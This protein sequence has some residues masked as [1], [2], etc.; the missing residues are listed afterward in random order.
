MRRHGFFVGLDF[1]ARFAAAIVLALPVTAALAGTGVGQFP[2]GDRLLFEPGGL[3]LLEAARELRPFAWSLGTASLFGFGLLF[4]VL[5]VPHG[6]LLASLSANGSQSRSAIFARALERLP[7]LFALSSLGLLAQIAVL[8]FAAS[9]GASVRAAL[10]DRPGATPELVGLAILGVGLVAAVL[11]GMARDLSRAA[12]VTFGIAGPAALRIGLGALGRGARAALP[13]W[14]GPALVSAL[15]V[16]AA[17]LVTGALDVSRPG[18]LRVVTV[19]VVHGVVGYAL[20]WCRAFWLSSS[21][22]LLNQRSASRR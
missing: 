2:E 9:T 13:A 19:F 3:Y 7:A 17:A 15:L 5:L 12:A 8:A 20:A 22:D 18:T 10:A 4:V 16:G 11:I 1:L 14:L 6:A 21:I